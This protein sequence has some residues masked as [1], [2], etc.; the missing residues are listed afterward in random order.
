VP[1]GF[2]LLGSREE[3]EKPPSPDGRREPHDRPK[4]RTKNKKPK[5]HEI[6]HPAADHL[7]QFVFSPRPHCAK[8]RNAAQPPHKTN[9]LSKIGFEPQKS[10]TPSQVSMPL[11]LLRFA[12]E[13]LPP[14]ERLRHRQLA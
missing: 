9:H 12:A 7:T 2:A 10:R 1:I 11:T 3:K 4:L 5:K 13:T 14:E 8:P 6:C